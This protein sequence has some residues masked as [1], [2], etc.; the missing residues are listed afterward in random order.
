MARR[1]VAVM[2]IVCSFVV[3]GS[4]AARHLERPVLSRGTGRLD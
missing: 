4:I 1:E 3:V 2:F